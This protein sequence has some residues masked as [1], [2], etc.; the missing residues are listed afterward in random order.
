MR[1]RFFGFVGQQVHR[2]RARLFLRARERAALLETHG[3]ARTLSLDLL[4]QW[5]GLEAD[6]QFRF[7]PPT[8]ALLAFRQALLELEDEGGLPGRA[9]RYRANYQVLID[10]M[11]SMGFREYLPPERQGYIITSFHYPEHPRF[12]FH[13]FYEL[14][15]AR[16][17][18]I[19]SGKLSHADCF[20]VG[21][22]GRIDSSDVRALL[23]AMRETLAEMEVFL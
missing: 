23:A 11:R 18:V 4:A 2:G 12:D 13:K 1:H 16:G 6:G 22:I 7:T 10:G 19:Y 8:H 17:H 20:R 15:S 5:E 9:A 14:L 21:S 3:L